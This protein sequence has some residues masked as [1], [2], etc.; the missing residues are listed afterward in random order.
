VAIVDRDE[1]D[2]G[3]N[4]YHDG[5]AP[6]FEALDADGRIRETYNPQD[7]TPGDYTYAEDERTL[8]LTGPG[9]V[10][11]RWDGKVGDEA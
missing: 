9:I 7:W 3:A 8:Y 1:Q 2:I 6:D 10:L 5:G 11:W 4:L